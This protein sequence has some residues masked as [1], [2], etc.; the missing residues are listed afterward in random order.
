MKTHPS[1]LPGLKGLALTG[2]TA[3]AVACSGGSD[4]DDV[5]SGGSSPVVARGVITQLG[6]V[7]VN[8][9]KYET[10][11]GG[12]YS[13][14][15]SN[16]NVADYEVG[17]VV[18]IRGQRNDDG[19][20][21][22]ADKVQY[23]A[24]IEGT[25]DA[26]GNINGIVIVQTPKTNA[27][28]IPNPL[29]NNVRYEISGIWID[30]NTIESTYI[31]VDD[32]GDGEDE[33][34][35]FVKNLGGG[36]FDVRS[37]GFTGY[38]GTPALSNGNFVEV[39]FNPATCSAPPNVTCTLT[40]VELEDDFFDQAEG[41]EIE[42][43][44][45]ANL[46]T[47]G[48]PVDADFKIDM[49]CIDWDNKPTVF[50]DGL[51]GPGDVVAGSRVEAEGHMVGGLL[52]ADKI[53]GRGN[54]VRITSIAGNVDIGPGTFD[55]IEGNIEVTTMNGVTMFEDGLTINTL[56]SGA[57]LNGI[58]VRGVRSGPSTMLA[59][60]IKLDDL[61]GGGDLHELRA[62]V[63]ENGADP[64]SNTLTVMGVVSVANANTELEIEDVEIAPGDGF[65]TNADIDA[66]LDLVDDDTNPV[67]GP[68][69]VV[70]I[71]VDIDTGDGK[72]TPYAADEWEIEEEDD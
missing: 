61:S 64:A 41:Q 59:L 45:A 56:D 42:I 16:G 31:K 35:G 66:F 48:C 9:V 5:V 34:K 47:S 22:V 39:H 1:V 13:N 3:L 68:R 70:E 20:T 30:N 33:I 51:T 54:R 12:S 40:S 28:G 7:Y 18:S 17:Q 24:E 19:A 38:T 67:N 8:G 60:R 53:K 26:S 25:A 62:E 36:S 4:D 63:D 32:D 72:A 14:D 71:E 44:G 23:E 27:Q 50:M 21:G 11:N 10:P 15:D 6:S 65:T 46:D 29:A 2:L 49:T 58:Q 43:E 69:D 57:A 37:I 52:V 55:L